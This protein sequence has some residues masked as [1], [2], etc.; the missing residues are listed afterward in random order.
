MI[1]S[2]NELQAALQKAVKAR[3]VSSG[4]ADEVSAAGAWL[5]MQGADGIAAVLDALHSPLPARSQ[6]RGEPPVF[7]DARVVLAGPSA[8]DLLAANATPTVS[9]THCDSPLLL[10]GLAAVRSTADGIAYQILHDDAPQ[11]LKSLALIANPES[12]TLRMDSDSVPPA[13]EHCTNID[14]DPQAW[15]KLLKLAA[16]MYVPSS[17]QS[18]QAGAGAGLLDND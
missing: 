9:L 7:I 11:T 18:R 5:S 17:E 3:G 14:V 8:L 2:Q 10:A 4:L 12:L 15:A 16:E 1:C 6:T 13:D